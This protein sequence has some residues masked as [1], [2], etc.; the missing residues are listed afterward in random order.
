MKRPPR[1]VVF[2]PDPSEYDDPYDHYDTLEEARKRAADETA[3]Y[4]GYD[5]A[6]REIYEMVPVERYEQ[7]RGCVKTPLASAEDSND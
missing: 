4:G 5:L 2:N 6:V 7:T 1:F 3:N